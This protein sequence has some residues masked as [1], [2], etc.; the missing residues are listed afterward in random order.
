[1]CCLHSGRSAFVFAADPSF[2]VI[3][4][5]NSAFN[6]PVVGAA[7]ANRIS[8][9]ISP[10]GKILYSY[11]RFR[12]GETHREYTS[13][14][15]LSPSRPFAS[16]FCW[17]SCHSAEVHRPRSQL[18]LWRNFHPHLRHILLSYMEYYNSARTN[19]SLN[20]DAPVPRGVQAV[21]RILPTPILGGLQHHYVRI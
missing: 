19:L 13:T 18:C 3:K 15:R 21:G 7:F 4:A 20:K 2:S 16:T 9:V 14:E 17:L 10:E 1:M 5:Y 11:A 6:I 12:R 8:Y